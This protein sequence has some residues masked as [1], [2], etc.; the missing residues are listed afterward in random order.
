MRFLLATHV[1]K[2]PKS[3]LHEERWRLHT[4]VKYPHNTAK[5]AFLLAEAGFAY[6][7]NGKGSDDTVICFFCRKMKKDWKE[8]EDI[9]EAHRIMSPA[10]PMVTGTHCDNVPYVA[11]T[12]V[13]FFSQND[14]LAQSQ[15]AANN[16]QY[17]QAADEA[18]KSIDLTSS[19]TVPSDTSLK[20]GFRLTSTAKVSDTPQAKHSTQARSVTTG[21]V[22]EESQTV[23]DS[24][25]RTSSTRTAQP[26]ASSFTS[27]IVSHGTCNPENSSPFSSGS[28]IQLLTP[29]AS[30]NQS[31]APNILANQPSTFAVSANQ[32]ST[33]AVSANQSSTPAVPANQSSIP[34]VPANQSSNPDGSANQSWNLGI[35]INQASA[36]AATEKSDHPTDYDVVKILDKPKR[37]EYADYQKRLETFRDWP[38][39]HHLRKEDLADAGF[40]SAGDGD[41]TSCFHCGGRFR[42]W[43]ED[44]DVWVEHAL[45]F[46]KCAFIRQ[47]LGQNFVETVCNLRWRHEKI[48]FQM[49]LEEM[50]REPSAFQNV[51]DNAA[52]MAVRNMGYHDKDILSAAESI[53]ENGEVLSAD[54]LHTTLLQKRAPRTKSSPEFKNIPFSSNGEI[55]RAATIDSLKQEN[56]ELRLRFVCKICMNTQVGTVFLPC[57]HLVCCKKCGETTK[58]CPVCERP[59]EE[60]VRAFM[61]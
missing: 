59:V 13:S 38:A 19:N 22:N 6:I 12:N 45:W 35:S 21:V 41:C 39:D 28:A 25:Q 33:F 26:Q 7:G 60:V 47:N 46:S 34:D 50:N 1:G 31:S 24:T 36:P 9:K 23:P 52:V 15:R 3:W 44:N 8:E 20:S 54:I 27:S 17:L 14:Q 10:C 55:D 40:Y 51:I 37:Y 42:S 2:I 61:G 5:S 58:N 18:E 57:G 29:D 56:D 11:A 30:A 43:E 48:S 53:K 16:T 4:F 32:S 49:V